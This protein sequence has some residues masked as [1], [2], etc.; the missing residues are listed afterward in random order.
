MEWIELLPKDLLAS[1]YRANAEMAWR[2]Q[3]AIRVIEIL[4]SADY[5]ILGLEVWLP[6]KPG[7]TIPTPYIYG[8]MGTTDI[9]SATHARSAEEYVQT[10]AWDP[11][12]KSHSAAE[13]YFN[14]TAARPS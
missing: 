13:P 1:A 2:R 8:W 12:D 3:D 6:T 4:R 7:P 11:E 14:I 9:S 5:M 10:F